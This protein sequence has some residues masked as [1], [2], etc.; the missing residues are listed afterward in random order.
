[1]KQYLRL[2]KCTTHEETAAKIHEFKDSLTKKKCQNY[3]INLKKVII[4]V[5]HKR[6]DWSNI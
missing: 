3:I 6:G 5:I 4:Q 1:M 2:N